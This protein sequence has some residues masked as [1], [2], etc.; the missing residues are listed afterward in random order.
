MQFAVVFWAVRSLKPPTV[1]AVSATTTLRVRHWSLPAGASQLPTAPT[2]ALD[3]FDPDSAAGVFWRDLVETAQEVVRR[4]VHHQ[5]ARVA[6][7][8]VRSDE[9]AR[10][11]RLSVPRRRP[12]AFVA[13][14][15]L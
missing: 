3:A 6:R 7:A 8:R 14:E 15:T 9:R 10:V 11:S 12:P 13:L 5:T 4:V 2:M 1:V